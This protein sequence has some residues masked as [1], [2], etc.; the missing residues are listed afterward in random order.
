MFRSLTSSSSFFSYS[1]CFDCRIHLYS[2]VIDDIGEKRELSAISDDEPDTGCSAFPNDTPTQSNNLQSV[3]E[4]DESAALINFSMTEN[5]QKEIEM[6]PTTIDD[7]DNDEPIEC[8][9]VKQEY[10]VTVKTQPSDCSVITLSSEESDV[11]VVHDISNQKDDELSI[12]CPPSELPDDLFEND[13]SNDKMD[14]QN[15]RK[16]QFY[17]YRNVL[18]NVYTQSQ[19]ILFL[20]LLLAANFRRR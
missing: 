18:K 16:T 3:S 8:S 17:Q 19:N 6:Q 9:G 2:S 13:S 12:A 11:V 20:L 15:K 4:I 5:A 14:D 10:S 7:T 1:H